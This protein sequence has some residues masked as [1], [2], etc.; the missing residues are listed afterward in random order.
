G[1]RQAETRET[2]VAFVYAGAALGVIFASDLLTVFLFWEV[3]AVASTVV[4][5]LGGAGARKAGFRYIVVHILGGVLLMAGI[6]GEIAAT[7][8]SGFTAMTADSPAR[9]LILL[10]FLINAGA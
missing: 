2:P 6:A 10:G 4:V 5:W 9:W 7:G 8:S 3:M 1:L